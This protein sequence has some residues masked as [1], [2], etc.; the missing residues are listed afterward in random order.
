MVDPD[1]ILNIASRNYSISVSDQSISRS[2]LSQSDLETPPMKLNTK[3]PDCDESN[4]ENM[5]SDLDSDEDNLS[6]IKKQL[7]KIFL[8]F[9][10][11]KENQL[12]VCKENYI[13]EEMVEHNIS[14]EIIIEE[15]DIL[16]NEAFLI[17][18]DIYS[19]TITALMTGQVTPQMEGTAIKMSMMVFLMQN[20]LLITMMD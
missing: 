9:N 8:N 16:E 20:A 11:W 2:D 12:H 18:E 10:D 4:S 19:Q 13:H 14:P 17:E 3:D 1:A 6:K 15:T 7:R 5:N